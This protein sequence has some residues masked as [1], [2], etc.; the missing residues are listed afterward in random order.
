[1]DQ[2]YHERLRV[3]LLW[4]V[5][6]L[7]FALTFVTAVGFYVSPTV[8]VA[9]GLLTA[10]G[11]AVALVRYGSIVLVIDAAGLHAGRAVLE[12]DYLGDVRVLDRGATRRR[13]GRDADPA[14]WLVLRGYLQTSV[15]VTV[16]DP[17][18]PHPY[19]LISTRTPQR[20]ARALQ[21]GRGALAD[22]EV[23]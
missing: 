23:A 10:V 13:L 15:E 1:M 22:T 9:A 14:A 19:W 4:W 17:Q 20:L 8:A 5:I 11:V 21:A 18:D 3:P 12:W 16:A 6:A 2:V 7:F